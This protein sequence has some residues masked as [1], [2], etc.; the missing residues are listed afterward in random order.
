MLKCR[1]MVELVTGYLEGVLP[2]RLRLAARLHLLLCGP[3]RR[4]VGQIRETIRFLA[5]GPP[6]SPPPSPS[7]PFPASPVPAREEEILARLLTKKRAD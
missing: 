5:G 3:C 6:P 7:S 1:D 4:Y 2:P